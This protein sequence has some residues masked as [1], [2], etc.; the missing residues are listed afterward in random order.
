MNDLLVALKPQLILYHA[1]ANAQFILGTHQGEYVIVK[2]AIP[3]I[4]G[5]QEEQFEVVYRTPRYAEA[6]EQIMGILKPRG[7]RLVEEELAE[8]A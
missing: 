3:D 2:M 4:D 7:L 8:A 5:V 6:I 1:R